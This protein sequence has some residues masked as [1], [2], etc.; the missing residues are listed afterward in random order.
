MQFEVKT[1]VEAGRTV[2]AVFGECDLA[3]RAELAT[4]LMAAVRSAEVV[5]VDAAGVEFL[6]SSGIHG[7]VTAYQAARELG[8]RLYV[9]NASGEVADVLAMTG[10]GELLAPPG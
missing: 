7:L 10:V 5:V 4:A 1:T 2:V 9:I 8:R 6:D 3:S